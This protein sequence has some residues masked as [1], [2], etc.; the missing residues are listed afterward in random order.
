MSWDMYNIYRTQRTGSSVSDSQVTCVK[1]L[2]SEG[3]D[4]AKEV[5]DMHQWKLLYIVW[6]WFNHEQF[7]MW[8]KST[9][10]NNLVAM[11]F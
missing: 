5:K 2:R 3:F 11:D 8:R 6:L 9:A 7:Y 1:V 4:R 10:M